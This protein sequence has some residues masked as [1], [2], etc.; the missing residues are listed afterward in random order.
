MYK[1]VRSKRRQIKKADV[2]L[3]DKASTSFA[4]LQFAIHTGNY[5]I[6]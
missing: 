6:K 4:G 5:V 2:K 1:K 3:N